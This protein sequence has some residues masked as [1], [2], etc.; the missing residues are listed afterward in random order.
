MSGQWKSL[1]NIG[2]GDSRGRTAGIGDVDV[3]VSDSI[4]VAIAADAHIFGT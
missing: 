1:T 3:E 4:G 2:I